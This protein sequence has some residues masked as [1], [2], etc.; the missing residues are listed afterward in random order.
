[1]FWLFCAFCG[2][3]ANMLVY[4][5]VDRSHLYKSPKVVPMVNEDVE[6]GMTQQH[7]TENMNYDWWYRYKQ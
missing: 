5:A 4:C 6:L 7:R 3:I 2:L 1:M